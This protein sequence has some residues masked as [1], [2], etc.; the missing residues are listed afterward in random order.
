MRFPIP[1]A[2]LVV[3]LAAV[4]RA[5]DVAASTAAPVDDY[6]WAVYTS[7]SVVFISMAVYLILTHRNGARLDGE[8][9]HLEG[10]INDLE[11]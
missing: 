3:L 8:I 2:L 9:A 1:T 5:E 7:C 11:K 4:A 6:R 10:R